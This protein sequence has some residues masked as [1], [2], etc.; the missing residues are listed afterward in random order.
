METLDALQRKITT[1][2]TLHSLV[3][4]MKALAAVSIRQYEKAAASLAE[5][6]RTIELGFQVVLK[7]Y[8]EGTVA[9]RLTPRG[10]VGGIVIGSDQGMCGALNEQI[11]SHALTTLRRLGV[12]EAERTLVA[13]GQ[14]ITTRL[15]DAGEMVEYSLP[16]PGSAEGIAPAVHSLVIT[17]E[18]WRALQGVDR[19]LLFYHRFLSGT[20]YR[21]HWLQLLPLDVR[22]LRALARK[23]WPSRALPLLTMKRDRLFSRLVRQYL[24]VVLARAFAE[25]LASENAGRLIAMQS[26]ERNILERF[27]ALQAQFHEQR[28]MEITGEL[29]DIVAGF[30]ALGE[31][32]FREA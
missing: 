31:S 26:A 12:A 27:D 24:F 23:P 2:E 15:E 3:K 18:E 30:E 5:Y 16:L 7:G 9:P 32:R 17:L 29:L 13:V 8:P 22:W 19:L 28:Q 6:S 1:A 11:V 14:R 10:R 4:T 21:P 25:S 20:V